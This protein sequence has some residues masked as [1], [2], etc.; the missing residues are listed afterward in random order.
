VQTV[1]VSGA[2]HTDYMLPAQEQ[3]D[4]FLQTLKIESSDVDL[5]SN[6]T[7]LKYQVENSTK[8]GANNHTESICELLVRQIAE[9]VLWNSVMENIRTEL[10][11]C[12]MKL[13]EVGPGRQLKA[14]SSK[15]DR[16]LARNTENISI[17]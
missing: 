8:N 10:V 15:I 12:D 13:Y 1:N 11:G 5:Y 7:G 6:V 9:P 16:K 2:F 17:T 3:L 4:S 14:I